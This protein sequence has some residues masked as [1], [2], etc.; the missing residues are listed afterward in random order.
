MLFNE[1][2]FEHTNWKKSSL[3]QEVT[4]RW[5]VKSIEAFQGSNT[6]KL[7]IHTHAHGTRPCVGDQPLML[8]QLNLFFL[9]K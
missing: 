7:Y 2:I 9:K 4:S 1:V 6:A 3:V 5:C 8:R